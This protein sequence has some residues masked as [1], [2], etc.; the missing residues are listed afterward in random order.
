ML[1]PLSVLWSLKRMRALIVRN[2]SMSELPLDL[3]SLLYQCRGPV[4]RGLG[5][6]C[7]AV[8]F[9]QL[10]PDLLLLSRRPSVRD[11]FSLTTHH[12]Q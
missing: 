7:S 6:L 12:K 3:G 8:L 1:G 11:E 5:S 2:R 4:H 10:Q 9:L